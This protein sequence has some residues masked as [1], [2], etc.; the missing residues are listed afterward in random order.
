LLSQHDLIAPPDL[1]A[2]QYELSVLL[3]HEG[4]PAG[5]PFTLGVIDISTPLHRFDV[6]PD[7]AAPLDRTVRLG[8]KISLAGYK[9]DLADQALKVDLYWQTQAALT[10]RYKVF[11][12]LLGPANQLVAQSDTVPAAGQRPTTGWLAQEI[13][14]D[15]HT[16]PLPV[17][18]TS[19]GQSYWLITGLYDPVNGQRLPILD[20]AGQAVADAILVAEV[21]LP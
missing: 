19:T 21:S 14:T 6:P 7:A 17:D 2:G 16:L 13:I 20:E 12:Q 5:E 11:A 8:G 18:L 15:P 4:R 10:R 1:A 9:L 3:T